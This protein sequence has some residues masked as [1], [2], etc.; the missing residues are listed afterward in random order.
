MSGGVGFDH[1]ADVLP[2]PAG[3]VGVASDDVD[4]ADHPV[5]VGGGRRLNEA[6]LAKAAE[7]KL[8]RASGSVRHH[9]G[10]GERGLSDRLR[11]A[12]QG[13]AA[14][15]GYL[16]ADPGRRRRGAHP[17]AGPVAGGGQ[18][19]ARGR[20]QTA[21]SCCTGP[22]LGTWS[23]QCPIQFGYNG[24][25]FYIQGPYDDVESIARMLADTPARPPALRRRLGFGRRRRPVAAQ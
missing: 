1:L 14:D 7:A 18:A 19:R 13:G 9:G 22:R 5:R 25:P 2:D 21:L 8:L 11:V 4:E 15:R 12:G 17:G 10:A 20:G 24:S 3:W 6:L 23:G 16:S